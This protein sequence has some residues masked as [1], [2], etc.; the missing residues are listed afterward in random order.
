VEQESVEKLI[1]ALDRRQIYE[2]RHL[3]DTAVV[4]DRTKFVSYAEKGLLT[5][6]RMDGAAY[7]G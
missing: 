2:A 6:R 4:K 7:A 1:I 3:S 5:C